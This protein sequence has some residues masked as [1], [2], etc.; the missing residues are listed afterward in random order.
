[1]AD[2]GAIVYGLDIGSSAVGANPFAANTGQVKGLN[3]GAWAANPLNPTLRKPNGGYRSF[4]LKEQNGGAVVAGAKCYIRERTSQL[5]LPYDFTAWL[6]P[7]PYL[8]NASGLVVFRNLEVA[9][10]TFYTVIAIHPSPGFN[11]ARFDLIQA[12]PE[13]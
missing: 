8:S 3:I 1:M 4:I 10:D 11:A 9:A 6:P 12:T 13:T 2:L 5:V 7:V